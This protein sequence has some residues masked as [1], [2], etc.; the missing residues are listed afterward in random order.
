MGS[1]DEESAI[2]WATNQAPEINRSLA[3][4]ALPDHI[5]LFSAGWVHLKTLTT[6]DLVENYE[7]PAGEACGVGGVAVTR[8]L[9]A[10]RKILR[11]KIKRAPTPAFGRAGV[12]FS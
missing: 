10:V 8:E 9:S 6:S 5:V 2:H 7:L 11:S 1:I 4:D 3:F 12:Q